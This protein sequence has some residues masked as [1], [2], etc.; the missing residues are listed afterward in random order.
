MQH[1]DTQVIARLK[2][3]GKYWHAHPGSTKYD[4]TILLF[5][6]EPD[7]PYVCCGRLALVDMNESARPIKFVWKLLDIATLTTHQP[8]QHLLAFNQP[9]ATRNIDAA[10]EIKPEAL[11]PKTEDPPS[12]PIPF[13]T[14]IPTHL[15]RP[16]VKLEK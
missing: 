12:P 15:F 8:F 11:T 14:A 13:I 2:R 1:P 3:A 16:A 10:P 7:Q 9:Q 5:V 4:T 6:R